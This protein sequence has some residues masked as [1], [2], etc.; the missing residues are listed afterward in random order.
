MDLGRDIVEDH[1]FSV[2][3]LQIREDVAGFNALNVGF[4]VADSGILPAAL[5]DHFP[6]IEDLTAHR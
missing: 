6:D 5:K 3:I 4:S 1:L 2:V